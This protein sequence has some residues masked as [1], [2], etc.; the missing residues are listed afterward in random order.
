MGQHSIPMPSPK[1]T[2][3]A[4]PQRHV[5]SPPASP[6]GGGG[7]PA[8]KTVPNAHELGYRAGRVGPVG[9]IPLSPW[10]DRYGN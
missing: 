3:P 2:G 7:L 4:E 1:T 8:V 9:D 5:V 10:E 6:G